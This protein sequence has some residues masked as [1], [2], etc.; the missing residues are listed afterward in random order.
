MPRGSPDFGTTAPRELTT[1][2]LDSGE[3]AARLGSP[4]VYDRLGT[5][6]GLWIADQPIFPIF[7]VVLDSGR[8]DTILAHT[9]FGPYAWRLTADADG[10]VPGVRFIIPYIGDSP[11]AAEVVFRQVP[12]GSIDPTLTILVDNVTDRTQAG[13]RWHEQTGQWQHIDS[14]GTFVAVPAPPGP[15]L[16]SPW[17]TLKLVVDPI[18][19]TY[20]RVRFNGVDMGLAGTAADD[21]A[22]S[23]RTLQVDF[24]AEGNAAATVSIEVAAVIVTVNEL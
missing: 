12:A 18:E 9:P 24:F 20:G 10:E 16:I 15:H 2:Q 6:I 1:P 5:V 21:Q 8:R 3:L 11:V 19:Q 22:G 17:S 13:A 23:I 4:N 7:P 14:G